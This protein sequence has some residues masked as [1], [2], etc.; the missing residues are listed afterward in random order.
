MSL[1]PILDDDVGVRLEEGDELLV[2]GNHFAVQDPALGLV[3]DLLDQA[4]S[5]AR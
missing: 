4:L 2:G 5:Y 3:E 1:A